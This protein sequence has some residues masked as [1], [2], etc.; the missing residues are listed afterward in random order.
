MCG[1]TGC[2][3]NLNAP[4]IVSVVQD[5]FQQV[6]IGLGHRRE[7]VTRHGGKALRQAALV[8]LASRTLDRL[9]LPYSLALRLRDAGVAPEVV[10]EYVDVEEASRGHLPR[11]RSETY[12]GAAAD[13]AEQ[14][15]L[16]PY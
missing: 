1:I 10:C 6:E 3:G 13:T 15:W 4:L 12:C 14:V 2:S 8:R 7:E 9:P 5:D 11:R 16:S